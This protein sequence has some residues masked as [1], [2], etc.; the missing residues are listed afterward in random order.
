M[1]GGVFNITVKDC[2]F[3]GDGRYTYFI[4]IAAAA[5]AVCSLSNPCCS[6]LSNPTNGSDFAGVHLKTTRGRGGGTSGSL[7]SRLLYSLQRETNAFLEVILA[8]DRAVH[9]DP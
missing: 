4:R 5:A 9:S 7:L 8:A 3:G 6:S 2:V 1:S